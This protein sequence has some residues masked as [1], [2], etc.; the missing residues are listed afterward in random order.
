MNEA[1]LRSYVR[2]GL[3]ANG[4]L[5]THHEDALNP[6]IPDLS[7]SGNGVHGWIELKWLEAWPKR[8]DTIVRILHYTK[9][10]KHFLLS[11]GRAGGRCWLLL[12]VGREHL[13]FSHELAQDVGK[14]SIDWLESAATIYWCKN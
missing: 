3:L 5:T 2:K 12:R 4:I 8:E 9:E 10:Q 11:R 13:L 1:T 6:G 7:Y 14:A